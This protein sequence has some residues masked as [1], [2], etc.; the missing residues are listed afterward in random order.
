[1]FK[2]LA[3][4]TLWAK[5]TISA[6]EKQQSAKWPPLITNVSS[7]ILCMNG[8]ALP[9]FFDA[10]S[11]DGLNICACHAARLFFIE[12]HAAS[13]TVDHSDARIK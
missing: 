3:V 2:E 12:N 6:I 4:Q 5:K 9:I 1:M 10:V 11:F 7:G 8:V 13:Q